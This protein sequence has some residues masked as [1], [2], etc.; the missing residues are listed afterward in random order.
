MGKKQIKEQTAE[1]AIKSG[2]VVEKAI[3]K[4][5]ASGKQSSKK[6]TNGRVYIKASYN[7]TVVTVTDE[8]G[9]VLA[10]ASAG[11]LGFNGPKKATPFASSKVIIALAEKLKKMGL[12]NLRIFVNGI[13]GGRD[14]AIR[15]LANQGFNI[16]TLKDVTPVPHN[17]VKPPKVRRV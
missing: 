14:S 16:M 1:E 13:G 6:V 2:E 15:S 3:L 4:S 8:K 7:N 17:G 11:S 5:A 10:W 9:D 12:V